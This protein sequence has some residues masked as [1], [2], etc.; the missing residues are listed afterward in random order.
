M[1][2]SA[3][4][5]RSAGTTAGSTRRGA[6]T[7]PTANTVAHQVDDLMAI[8]DRGE[9]STTSSIA[10][11]SMGVQVG[12]ET[13]RRHPDA[14]AR[15]ARDQRH[16]RP[17]VSHGDGQPARRPD[18]PDAAPAREGAGRARRAR[19]APARRLGRADQR[20]EEGR[21]RL[22]RRS[23][24]TSSARSRAG[25]QTIDWRIYSDLLTRLDEHDA[26]DVLATIDV[27]VT[28]VTGDRDLMT[29]PSTAEHMHRTIPRLAPRRDRGRHALHARRVSRRSSSRSSAACSIASPAGS[30]EPGGDGMN[31]PSVQGRGPRHRR[32]VPALRRRARR[33]GRAPHARRVILGTYEL[34]DVLGQGGMSVVFKA[35][36]KLTEQEV[37]LKI[38]PP[39]LAAHSQVKSRFLEEAKALAA[40]DHPNI[41][42]LYNFGQENGS[43]VLAMQYVQGRTW[44]RMILEASGS[45]GSA[46]C[47]IAIDVLKALEYA[48][49]RGIVHRDMKPSNVLVREQ[50][51]HGDGHGLRHREDDDVDEAHR[52]RPDDG[53]GPLHV[54]RA[55]A[56]PGGRPPHRHLLARRDAVRVARRRHA[57]RRQHALRDHDEAP[58]GGAE[59]AERV[60]HRC[61]RHSSRTR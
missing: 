40:L 60:G 23:T 10:G 50:R 46:S 35:K 34:V 22:R 28:I 61:C 9:A 14:R 18:D 21:P 43:F 58:L 29:P 1:T 13:I 33:D 11:W 52:D 42:H 36:H 48:H 59:A 4:T 19:D 49:G 15:P 39:E 20:D 24:S 54:A 7:D 56:R 30:A 27:P 31:C 44:E 25:F 38:L 55:G 53:H 8:L 57:V 51:R 12:F 2:R 3:T 26:E 47:R 5:A 45:T 41:V 32:Q 6:P 37:A 17:R 16:V